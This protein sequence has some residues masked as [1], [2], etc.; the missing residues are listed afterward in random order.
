MIRLIQRLA[1]IC[2]CLASTATFAADH[3]INPAAPGFL[4]EESDTEALEIADRVMERLGGRTALDETRFVTWKFFGRRFHVWDRHT[5][6][7]RV[8]GTDRETEE[9]YTILLNLHSKEGRAWKAGD[10][11]TGEALD[12]LLENGESAWINDSYWLFMPYKLKDTGVALK[13][14]GEGSMLDGRTAH[15]LELT[16][17]EVGRTPENKYHVYVGK[18]SDLVEQ[19]DFYANADDPEP[20]FQ[21]P[22]RNWRQRGSILLS[23]D[24]GRGQHSDIA[25][26]EE[27]PTTVFEGPEPVDLTQYEPAVGSRKLVEAPIYPVEG[28]VQRPVRKSVT[29]PEYPESAVKDGTEGKVV[30]RTVIGSDGSIRDAWV[31]ESLTEDLDAAALDT[32][33]QW[34][35]DPATLHGRPVDIYY[36]LT[37][38]FGLDGGA[39]G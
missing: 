5:G 16:F 31:T 10:E 33:R 15:V 1:P 13:S 28:D 27:L 6:D 26:F 22:W 2:F 19:W 21:V 12:E 20:G 29:Q 14:V 24:R 18:D 9:P 32:V 8:E 39:D 37:V 3:E 30:V 38:N 17:R 11:V 7:V 23:D 25:I 34:K 4:A 35:F 36:N